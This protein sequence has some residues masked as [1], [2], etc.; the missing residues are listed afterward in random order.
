M[1]VSISHLKAE[2]PFQKRPHVVWKELHRQTYLDEMIRWSGRA[3]FRTAK[4]CPDCATRHQVGV[5]EF[6]CQEC[7]LADLVCAGCC[8]RRHRTQ[9]L[10]WIE[11]S[12]C[13]YIT[14]DV[15]DFFRSGLVSLLHLSP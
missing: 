7:F 13:L 3:D 6:R 2:N 12:Y 9:P 11:V 14:F 1:T 10:H 4:E 5:P 8:L 15:N